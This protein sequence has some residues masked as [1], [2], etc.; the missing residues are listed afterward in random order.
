[1]PRPPASG[2]SSAVGSSATVGKPTFTPSSPL[3]QPVSGAPLVFGPTSATGT[4]KLSVKSA[5]EP[6]RSGR[7][8]SSGSASV[9]ASAS[10]L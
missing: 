1:M 6:R 9:G 7:S 10:A 4:A 3:W 8:S 2:P 5:M